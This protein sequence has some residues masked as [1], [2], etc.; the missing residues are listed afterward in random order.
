M[1][2][3]FL[4][5]VGFL[6]L[7]QLSF[8]QTT[9]NIVV[10]TE[11]GEKFFLS[12]NGEQQNTEAKTSVTV[13][14]YKKRSCLLSARFES[15]TE[16]VITKKILLAAD[17]YQYNYLLKKNRKGEYV[18]KTRIGIDLNPNAETETETEIKDKTTE[19]INISTISESDFYEAKNKIESETFE[20]NKLNMAKQLAKNNSL[21]SSHVKKLMKL[22]NCS[23]H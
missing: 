5:I 3:T 21:R 14:D 10:Y 18:L 1:K 13:E 20:N 17:N 7:T 11:K 16:K 23:Y 12:I 9:N 4:L 6:F 8:S 22:F 19:N 2:N 15:V